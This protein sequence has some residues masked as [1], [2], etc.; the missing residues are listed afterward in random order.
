MYIAVLV[1]SNPSTELE[2]GATAVYQDIAYTWNSKFQ[3]V[4][5]E[6][7]IRMAMLFLKGRRNT[8]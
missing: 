3:H 4:K 1:S 2:P 8:R 5:Y 6:Y 7:D